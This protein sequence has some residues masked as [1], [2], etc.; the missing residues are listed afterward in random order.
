V[1][2]FVARVSEAIPGKFPH[3]AVAHAGYDAIEL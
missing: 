1:R 2:G 3:I